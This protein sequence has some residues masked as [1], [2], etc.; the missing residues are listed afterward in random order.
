MP[1]AV[2]DERYQSTDPGVRM[3][4]YSSGEVAQM[5]GIAPITLRKWSVE[6]AAWLSPAGTAR[7]RR[8]ADA[9]LHVLERAAELLKH[10]RSYARVRER[11]AAE[12]SAAE[13]ERAVG[14]VDPPAP[15][16]WPDAEAAG[17]DAPL[18]VE[19]EVIEPEPRVAPDI[20]AMLERMAE[21]YQ[22]LLRNKEQEIVA[23][24]QALDTTEL[25]AANE[26]RELEM[27]NKLSRI[28]ERENQRLTAELE[29]AR[30]Q[31]GQQPAERPTWRSRMA[32]WLGR[33]DKETQSAPQI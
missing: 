13:R 6:F 5:L 9:D 20:A 3:D 33:D 12:F 18:V 7:E 27:L 28:M 23:L 29:D 14:E 24:R 17:D 30:R 22:D 8:Y 32:R 10:Q 21:L 19:A 31:L 1:T 16:P 4:L 15:D 11:R 2:I 25:A 26:R